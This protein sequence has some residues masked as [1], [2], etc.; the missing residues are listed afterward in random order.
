[1]MDPNPSISGTSGVLSGVLVPA[2]GVLPT[3]R[4]W[5]TVVLGGGPGR[6]LV[7]RDT[8]RRRDGDQETRTW[9]VEAQGVGVPAS[10][11]LEQRSV[12]FFLGRAG[13]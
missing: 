12:G 6:G 5:S 2:P 4:G 1:M 7:P 10:H 13:Y 8:V 3:S 11:A 9:T